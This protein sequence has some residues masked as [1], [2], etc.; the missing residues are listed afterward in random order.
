[1][2]SRFSRSRAS[3]IALALCLVAALALAACGS[4]DNDSSSSGTSASSGGNGNNGGFDLAAYEKKLNAAKQSQSEWQGPTDPVKP[5]KKFKLAAITCYSILHGCVSPA[6]SAGRAAKALGWDFQIY[7]GKGDP[8]VW[9]QRMDQAISNGA[10]AIITVAVN[11][12]AIKPQLEK[13]KKAGVIVVSTSNASAP[14]EQGFMLDTSPNLEAVG[15]AIADW[16]IVDSKGKATMV[17]Y[18]D[19][20][21][22]S[23]ISTEEGLLQEFKTCKTC[24]LK[25]TVNFVATDVPNN[26]GP[27]TA[28]YFRK[29]PNVDYFHASYDPAAT[30]QV[31]ALLQAG[32]G[33]KVTAC[34]ILGDAQ[35][36]KYIDEGKVQRCDGAWDNEYEGYATVDQIIRLATKK[37]L[38]VS[39]GVPERF[40]YGENIPYVLLDKTNLPEGDKDWT[41]SFDYISEYKKLWGLQ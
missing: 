31:P 21:F 8:G 14:G 36:L 38:H 1:M 29:N 16:M 41:A 13:A 40:K 15:R 30:V 6:E 5:P 18:L 26:L 34:S 2:A 32:L 19:K 17:P 23:N 25:P 33:D 7:D 12:A 9:A 27:S 3:F 20:E 22:Q 4:D 11:G 39:E 10:D 35:N 28:A 37:P 24:T